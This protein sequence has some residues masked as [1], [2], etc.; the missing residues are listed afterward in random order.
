MSARPKALIT[1]AT[2]GIGLAFARSLAASGHD[3]VLVARNQVRLD[4]VAADIT[5]S[6]GATCRVVSADLST[7]EGVHAA[8]VEAHEI[9]VLIANAGV[10]RAAKI[11]DAAPDDLDALM[12]L[13]A[14]GV[15]RL[16]EGV[17]PQ[18]RERKTGRIVVVS[19]IAALIPMPKSA[20]YAAAKA[21]VTSYAISAHHELRSHGV[22]VIVVNPGYV[23]TGLHQASGLGHLEQRIPRWLWIEP[24]DVVRCVE[25]GLDR[26]RASVVPGA[27]YRVAKP[28]L[29]STAA[30]AL[31]R[32]LARR[33]R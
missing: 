15:I 21:S 19:S 33:R 11:G 27:V 16:I 26:G 28:F 9:D 6:S 14:G 2:S 5:A 8:L 29:A 25:R 4:Q 10:T 20:V 17:A 3:L 24:Q 1:G 30:Q 32:K 18:M 13:L 12:M 22:K 31:W 7:V 23:R